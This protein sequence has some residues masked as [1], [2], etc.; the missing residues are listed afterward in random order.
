MI[1]GKL[2]INCHTEE[3]HTALIDYLKNKGFEYKRGFNVA[4]NPQKNNVYILIDNEITKTWYIP[5]P[6][7][8]PVS[9]FVDVLKKPKGRFVEYDTVLRSIEN[10]DN[11]M[12]I[13]FVSSRDQYKLVNI[14]LS[15]YSNVLQ[16]KISSAEEDIWPDYEYMVKKFNEVHKMISTDSSK[17]A[18]RLCKEPTIEFSKGQEDLIKF[19]TDTLDHFEIN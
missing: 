17:R 6:H 7:D 3:E 5:A 4:F 15:S 9:Y 11:T 16:I 10:R 1:D 8:I 18:V 2:G 12:F 13:H 14:E 19:F